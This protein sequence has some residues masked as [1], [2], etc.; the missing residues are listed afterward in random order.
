MEECVIFSV[1]T[2]GH[3]TRNKCTLYEQ[4]TALRRPMKKNYEAPSVDPLAP[5]PWGSL[6]QSS[7][8]R[9]AAVHP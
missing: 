1:R 7:S 2:E 8:E 6:E 5:P 4:S 3:H 9:A